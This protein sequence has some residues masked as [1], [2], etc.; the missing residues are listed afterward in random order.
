MPPPPSH[1]NSLPIPHLPLPYNHQPPHYNPHPTFFPASQ[2]PIPYS[3]IIQTPYIAHIPQY[4]PIP[5]PYNTDPPK[6]P[7][8]TTILS[9]HA[10]EHKE[11]RETG[12]N[13]F[14]IDSKAFK[15]TFDGGRTDPYNIS[16]RRG[17]YRGS[18]WVGLTGLRWL[19]DVFAKLRAKNQSIEGFFEFHRDGYRVIEL[20]CLANRG[21]RYV[22]I[23]EYHS[24]TH[25]GSVRIPEGRRGAGWSLFEFQVRKFFLGEITPALVTQA[26]PSQ[27]RD[28]GV[29]AVGLRDVGPDE[30]EAQLI[31]KNP[32]DTPHQKTLESST[33]DSSCEDERGDVGWSSEEPGSDDGGSEAPMRGVL[34]LLAAPADEMVGEIIGLVSPTSLGNA[35][36]QEKL[37]TVELAEEEHVRPLVNQ[38]LGAQSQ[39]GDLPSEPPVTT[40]TGEVGVDHDTGVPSVEVPIPITPMVDAF[41]EPRC[42]EVVR[43]ESSFVTDLALVRVDDF[44][45]AESSMILFHEEPD[46]QLSVMEHHSQTVMTQC[47]AEPIAPLTCEPLAVVAPPNVSVA[48]RKPHSLDRSTWV[49]TQYKGICELMGFPLESHEQQCLALLRRIEA[50][51]F[52]KKGEVGS[53]KMVVSGTKGARELR[54][55]LKLLTWNVRGLNDP[56]K[57]VV[58]KNWLRKWKVD[59]VCLQETKLDKV[60]GRMISSIWGNRFA[61]WEVLDATHTAGGV[62]LLWDKRVVERIDSKVGMFSVSCHWKSLGDGFEWVGTGVYGPNR[63]DSRSELWAELVEV[64]NQWS[65]PW[66]IFGDFNVVRFPSERRGCVRVTPAMEEFSD[67][68]DGFNL[69]DLPLNGGLYS[70]CNGAANPSMSR[71][72]RVLVS[73]DWEEHYPDVVQKLMPK[74]IS[75]HNPVLLEAGG[76]A[77]GKSSFKFENM[78][79]KVPEFVDKVQKWWSGYSYSGTPSFVL[80]QKLKALKGDLKEWNRLEFGDVGIK[81][82]QLECELQ[83]YDEKESLSSLSP[84]EHILREVCKAELERVA[85]LEEVSWR[86]KSRSLWLKEGDN[87]TKFFHKMAN[88]HRRYNYMDK[89]EVDGVVFE[90]ESE[91][92]EKVVHFYE[93]LYQEAETWRPTV[94]G[95]EF[96]MITENE[97]AV[98]E[99][100]FDKEEVLQVVKDY[101]GEIR[102]LAQMASLWLSSRNVGRLKG[103]LDKLISESQNAF[104]GGRKILDSVLI[105]NECLDSRL[106][107]RIPGVICKLDIEKAYDHVNWSCLLHLLERMGFGRRWRLWIESCISSVQ[108]SV[109]VNGSPEGFF[110]CSR[111]LRQGDPLSPLLFLLVMEVLSRMLRKVEEEGLIRGFRAGS[112]AAEGLCISHLL[113][114]DD[115]ILFCDA[116]LDQVGLWEVQNIAELADSLCCHI[117]GLPLSYLEVEKLQRDFLWG[118]MGDEVKHHLVGWDKVCTPKEVGGLGVRSLIL[119]NKALLGKWLWRFGMEGDHLWRRVLMAKF[120]SDLGGW[121]TKPIRGP[122]GCGLWKGIMSGWEDYFQHV[123]FVVGQGTRVSFWK[124]KWCGDTSLMFGEWNVTFVRDFNDWEV[125]VVAEFF[126]FLHSHMVPNAAPPD[127]LR[128][129][130]CKDGVFTSRSYHYALIDRRGVRFPWKSIWRVKAPPRVAFF[131][132]TATWGRILTC[133]NLMRRG[134]MMAGWCCM[135]CCD[136]ETV[137]HLLLHCSA[138]QKLWNYVFLTFR[139]HWVVPRQVADLLFG[140]H[141]WFGKHHSHIWNLIPLCLMWTVWRERN[142]RTFEDLSTSPDQLLGTFVTSLF[143]WTRIWGFTTAVTVTEFV[144]SWHSASV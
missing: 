104:V 94:D 83:A 57:R 56:K 37:V 140:W 130:Q 70:W 38:T 54:N 141:N 68:I 40:Q 120:G 77:R 32:M 91:I 12:G 98:L 43:P 64:R 59:V 2:P 102:L 86:Q 88:S 13:T 126:Q 143:D 123:E 55:L 128:W 35:Q 100:Q 127:E 139:V 105:A 115:T 101:A 76:M 122:H 137:D 82:Q 7:K 10:P 63:D 49:N 44:I 107:S 113:Y 53:R 21:G 136:G 29:T 17:Q 19:L 93:S 74:P 72:D 95:L 28:A 92:R 62:L 144:D 85:Q 108:F 42:A 80:A 41:E 16:E 97:S 30:V 39:G 5:L 3:Q 79:L 124:D 26:L 61:G 133:D 46:S 36:A 112:N 20:S 78:W 138:V 22:E 1:Q 69:I 60:D 33:E 118:G 73:T 66:C 121:R 71:I 111:G 15:L 114:A 8:S 52:I 50:A 81:R 65:Q 109:L 67:F 99:R 23:S 90:E 18:L 103:V 135:C 134:Y 106:K 45:E 4:Q 9:T 58:L 125:D 132:W 31:D 84:E 11:N 119:T 116:D 89:V 131:V 142:L 47:E 6:P 24:G 51:R 96:E 110:S 117:G 14:C 129:K 27:N 48:P 25:R 75:D 34:A 87:N